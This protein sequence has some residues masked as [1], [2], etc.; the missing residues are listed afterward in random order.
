MSQRKTI[1]RTTTVARRRQSGFSLLEVL[2]AL[3]VLSIG[4]LGLAALQTMGLKFNTQSYQR[5]QAVL[6]AYDIIDRMRANPAGMTA[7]LYNNVGIN[8]TPPALPTCPCNSTQ[9][10]DYD[11]NQWKNAIGA[12]LAQ[13]KGAVCRGTLDTNLACTDAGSGTTF[14]VGIEWR[15]NDLPMRMQV[16]AQL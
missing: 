15:E 11:I 4:L 2:I 6:Q 9:M 7:G 10:A 12:L 1:S 5:T 13:G 16:V 8:A 14:T 3:L